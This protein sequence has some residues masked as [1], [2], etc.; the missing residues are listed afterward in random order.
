MN[1]V[2]APLTHEN[3][4]FAVEAVI[5]QKL[6]NIVIARNSY[7]N[8]VFE[9]ETQ[10]CNKLIVKF[11]RPGRW[12]Q[13]TILAEHQFLEVLC[14]TEIP[15]IPPLIFNNQT[16]FTFENIYFALFPKMGGRA[17]DELDDESW[18]LIGRLLA[19]T[20]NIGQTLSGSARH[21]WTPQHVVS[22]SLRILLPHPQLPADYRLPLERSG[23]SFLAKAQ[24]WMKTI[25]LSLIHGDCHL[26]NLIHRPDEGLFLVDFDDCCIGPVVQDLWMLLPSDLEACQRELSCFLEGYSVFKEFPLATLK[27]IPVLRAMRRLY[28]AGWCALQSSDVGFE[29]HFPE[30]G[31]IRY[32]NELVKDIQHVEV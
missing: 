27:I 7:I 6:K 14:E 11:Y 16:L 28:F 4:L 19:R 8:R 23:E 22:Q 12:S 17:L 13:E 29:H 31:K 15:V 30:W 26:G 18:K 3:I 1:Q 32:W 20:H 21:S 10:D 5:G 9:L 2:W 24:Q 25:P